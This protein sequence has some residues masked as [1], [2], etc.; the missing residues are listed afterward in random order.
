M[1]L[2]LLLLS[3]LLASPQNDD[4]GTCPPPAKSQPPDISHRV[5]PKS[6]TPEV[7]YVGTVVLQLDLS[8]TGAICNV[9]VVQSEGEEFDKEA[10]S[11][12]RGSLLQAITID[13]KPVPGSM[14]ILRDYFRG[15]HNM[16]VA[17]T[18]NA[19]ED[20]LPPAVPVSNAPSVS[21]LLASGYVNGDNYR[22][23]YFGVSFTAPGA[24]V[25]IPK[26]NDGATVARLVDA[27]AEADD[28][29]KI[30]TLSL[31]ADNIANYPGLNSPGDYISS[32]ATALRKQESDVVGVKSDI[33]RVRFPYSISDIPFMG[34]I[35]KEQDSPNTHH[36][37][38]LFTAARKGYWLTLDITATTEE[39]ILKIASTVQLMNSKE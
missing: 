28:R 25:T 23:D 27:L 9:K 18:A 3:L 5:T 38:G 35:L 16:L 29:A 15:N 32:L 7:H 24:T 11:T 2:P 13:G 37:R 31:S 22:N 20:T 6:S 30:Y 14:F 26:P 33:V 36:Y 17:E 12:I 19:T 8:D 1:Y 4:K 21:A 34:A 39:R 10:L